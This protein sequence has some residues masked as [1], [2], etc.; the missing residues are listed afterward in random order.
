M[1]TLK[2]TTEIGK[3]ASRKASSRGTPAHRDA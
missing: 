3:A 1:P 2:P